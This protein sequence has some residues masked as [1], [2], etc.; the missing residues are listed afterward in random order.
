MRKFL[1]TFTIF[2]LPRKVISKTIET[3]G[4]AQNP[5]W[6]ST[7][8]AA[9]SAGIWMKP[10]VEE[11]DYAKGV[12][13]GMP[14]LEGPCRFGDVEGRFVTTEMRQAQ[15]VPNPTEYDWDVGPRLSPGWTKKEMVGDI[16]QYEGTLGTYRVYRPYGDS[17]RY[18]DDGLSPKPG[19]ASCG[20]QVLMVQLRGEIHDR[21]IHTHPEC[22]NFEWVGR[23]ITACEREGRIITDWQEA[24]RKGG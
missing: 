15:V 11:N 7:V 9:S 14:S 17:L 13:D 4:D 2:T 1:T 12:I 23:Y 19:W 20:P 21:H 5:L 16:H 22:R 10:W 24:W 8:A 3:V 18:A 6:D